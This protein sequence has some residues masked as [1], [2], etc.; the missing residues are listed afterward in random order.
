MFLIHRHKAIFYCS[1]KQGNVTPNNT[2]L[3][4]ITY[5]LYLIIIIC[6]FPSRIYFT[7]LKLTLFVI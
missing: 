2:L 1:I 4:L 7:V 3:I 5:H 6:Y